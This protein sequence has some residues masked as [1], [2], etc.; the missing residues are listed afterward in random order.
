M[1][2]QKN[3]SVCILSQSSIHFAIR[4]HRE[5]HLSTSIEYRRFKKIKKSKKY[6]LAGVLSHIMKLKTMKSYESHHYGG[7]N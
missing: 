4:C 5:K 1:I 6:I 2:I 7:C 3:R